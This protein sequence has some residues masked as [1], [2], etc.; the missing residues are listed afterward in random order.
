MEVK[1]FYSI[2]LHASLYVF[3]SRHLPSLF[4]FSHS[5]GVGGAGVHCLHLSIPCAWFRARRD[6]VLNEIGPSVGFDFINLSICS[7]GIF[8]LILFWGQDLSCSF[9]DSVVA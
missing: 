9:K 2:C 7:L 8:L 4:P 1:S 6:E 5:L 3:S